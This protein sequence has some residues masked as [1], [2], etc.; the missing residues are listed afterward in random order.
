MVNRSSNEK[1]KEFMRRNKIHNVIELENFYFK[2]IFNITRQL[3]AVPIVWEEV[4]FANITLDSNVIVH[5]WKSDFNQTLSK[6]S[7]FL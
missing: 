3:K 4:F 5:V 1:I 6:V 7:M 2:K